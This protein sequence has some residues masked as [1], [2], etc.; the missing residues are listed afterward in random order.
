MKEERRF[1]GNPRGK[2]AGKRG[3]LGGVGEEDG[4]GCGQHGR[5]TAFWEGERREGEKGRVGGQE[6]GIYGQ[7]P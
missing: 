3:E 1:M 5:K 4:G 7:N 6:R 2:T